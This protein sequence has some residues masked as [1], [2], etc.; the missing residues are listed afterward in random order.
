VA[1]HFLVAAF[2]ALSHERTD[3]YVQTERERERE[4][5]RRSIRLMTGRS[6]VDV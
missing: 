3:R 1:A 2:Y 4:R 6:I 5:D